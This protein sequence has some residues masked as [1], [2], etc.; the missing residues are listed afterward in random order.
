MSEEARG[1]TI[2]VPLSAAQAVEFDQLVAA[3]NDE[4][5][6][7]AKIGQYVVATDALMRGVAAMLEEKAQAPA[8]AG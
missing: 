4:L 7:G 3:V 1:R 6:R 8:S 2:N 5:P